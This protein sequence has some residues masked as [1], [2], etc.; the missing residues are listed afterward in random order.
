VKGSA[1]L[2]SFGP[3]MVLAKE[4]LER[5]ERQVVLE[6]FNLCG[7]FSEI[8][9]DGLLQQWTEQVKAGKIPDFGGNLAYSADEKAFDQ[10]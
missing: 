5:K 8:E 4:L 3:N 1:V 7:A 2:G 6:Y 10:K 9:K